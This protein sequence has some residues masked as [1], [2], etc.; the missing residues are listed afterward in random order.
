VV[1]ENITRINPCQGDRPRLR[2][3]RAAVYGAAFSARACTMSP[4]ASVRYIRGLAVAG[5][6]VTGLFVACSNGS[7]RNR[8]GAAGTGGTGGQASLRDAS[9]S[10]I[11]AL[12]ARPETGA[13]SR[14]SSGDGRA[15][16]SPSDGSRIYGMQGP[17][18]PWLAK[19][20]GA[21]GV[22]TGSSFYAVDAFTIV[23]GGTDIGGVADSFHFLYFPLEG[24]GQIL[25]RVGGI[26][27]ADPASKAGIMFRGSLDPAAANV[28]VGVVGD[29]TSG[30]MQHRPANGE[31]TTSAPSSD[32]LPTNIYLRIVR[33]GSTFTTH[34][35][36]DLKA[37]T[38][39][40]T[41]EVT[42][43]A[44]AFVGLA[45]EAH[46]ATTPAAA[47][48]TYAS[49]DNLKAFPATA[50]WALSDLGTMGGIA[51]ASQGGAALTLTGFGKPYT[52]PFDQYKY[53]HLA[54]KVSG[55]H[56]VTAKI[57]SL[58]SSEPGAR[59]GLMFRDSHGQ[60][61]QGISYVTS[62][63]VEISVTADHGVQFHR[64][65]GTG[66]L[67]A[68]IL[69]SGLKP[70]IWL[71]LANTVLIEKT[72]R[73]DAYYSKDGQQWTRVGFATLDL[74][75]TAAGVTPPEPY[76]FT[77]AGHSGTQLNTIQIESFSLEMGAPGLD[78]GVAP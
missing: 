76:G 40:G 28:F 74:P 14:D 34:R 22:L 75:R 72:N 68:D 53:T 47:I 56:T 3:V 17:P 27:M 1:D 51:I 49:I 11:P 55:S 59:A 39:I 8:D 6:A 61:S 62:P 4:I 24:D 35:S 23:A 48:F 52:T 32:L 26:R 71:K 69:V 60:E 19:D 41:A 16:A 21:V 57:A 66:P 20:I 43:P 54:K 7:S 30:R 31:M 42:M 45:V 18:A 29:G 78:A 58:S 63:Y 65:P 12:E 5:L 73:F 64:K 9:T 77:S 70:P 25:A 46:S 10:D 37:W 38:L 67:P 15:D 50:E 44:S 2:P 33:S 13:E 36:R